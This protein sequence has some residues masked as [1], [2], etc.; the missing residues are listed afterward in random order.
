MAQ[1]DGVVAN[2]SGAAV[3]ADL[4][5]QLLALIT[6]NSGPTAPSTT[7]AYQFWYDETNNQLKLRNSA[8]DGWIVLRTIAS[9][10][11]PVV[12]TSLGSATSTAIQPDGDADSGFFFHKDATN[13][14]HGFSYSVGG[15]EYLRLDST[16]PS[17]ANPSFRWL[18]TNTDDNIGI[19]SGNDTARDGIIFTKAGKLEVCK[20]GGFTSAFNRADSSGGENLVFFCQGTNVGNISVTSSSTAYNTSSDYRLKENVVDLTGAK[21]RLNQ[22]NVKRFNFI[23]APDR[24]VDGF[25]A[26]E[27][28]TVVPEAVTGTQDEMNDDGTPKYQGIDQAKLVPLLTAALQEAF[29]EI[30][31]LTARVETLEA[32]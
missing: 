30:A 13:N 23:N 32:G 1:A 20:H 9:G 19:Y 15:T 8:N 4:N 25:I 6:N 5:S 22:L 24:T 16:G 10:D 2:A 18:V 7:R 29:T 3:R 21:T 31:A 17:G 12:D 14:H 11:T 26:H 27:A 28:Q